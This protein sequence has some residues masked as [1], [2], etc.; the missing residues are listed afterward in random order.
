MAP[1]EDPDDEGDAAA[2]PAS[3][4]LS[5][6][7]RLAAAIQEMIRRRKI[8]PGG[9]LPTEHELAEHFGVGRNAIRE[10]V[11]V[12]KA[13]GVVTSKTRV[14]LTVLPFDPGPVFDQVIPQITSEED[15]A[16]LHEFRKIIELA[17]LPMV[18]AHASKEDLDRLESMLNEP[19]PKGRRAV[20][21]GLERDQAFHEGLWK[22]AR[23]P[24]IWSLRGLLLRYFRDI[25]DEHR[26]QVPESRMHDANAEHLAIVRALRAGDLDGAVRSMAANIG[27]YTPGGVPNIDKT[28]G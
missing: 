16:A 3:P 15:R 22:L 9:K 19:L 25:A 27:E 26:H 24:F 8:G 23:N 11:Q 5:S 13:A 10:A 6:P 20:R 28:A 14:G 7:R 1:E 12:L 18:R 4:R 2:D 21:V 17:V